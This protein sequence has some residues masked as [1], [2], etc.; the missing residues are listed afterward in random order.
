MWCL[1]T[2]CI[3]YAYAA[4]RYVAFGPVPADQLGFFVLNKSIGWT[5]LVLFSAA[6]GLVRSRHRRLARMF[7]VVGAWLVALHVLMALV[8]VATREFVWLSVAPDRLRVRGQL[9][10]L[11]GIVAACALAFQQRSTD[12]RLASGARFVVVAT[13]SLHVAAIG[14]PGWFRPELWHGGL[15]PIT[16]LSA[17]CGAFGMVLSLIRRRP[18]EAPRAER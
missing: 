7:G 10:L 1:G 8:L 9:A 15:P 5:A 13:G 2:W 12:H 6:L 17:L 4:V 18:R 14:L 3:A 11:A 16:L